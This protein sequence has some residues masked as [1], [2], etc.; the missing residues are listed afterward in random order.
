MTT[1]IIIRIVFPEKA[2]IQNFKKLL[3]P[4]HVRRFKQGHFKTVSIYHPTLSA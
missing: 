1:S 3:I 2:G 4:N